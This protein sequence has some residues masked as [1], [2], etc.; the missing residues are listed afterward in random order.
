MD[1]IAGMVKAPKFFIF[2][3][4]IEWCQA[5]LMSQ[6]PVQIVS[7]EYAGEKFQDYLRLMALCKHHII[8]NSTFAWWGAWLNPSK[9]KIVI[10]PRQWIRHPLYRCWYNDSITPKNWIKL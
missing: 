4:E 3:N 10:S 2:S 5:H 6:Y 8:P 9:D 1:K 7:P